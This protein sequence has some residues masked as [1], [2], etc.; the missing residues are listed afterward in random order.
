VGNLKSLSQKSKVRL[1]QL[2][3]ATG[4]PFDLTSGPN[5]KTYAELS[6][7]QG[8]EFIKTYAYGVGP[9]KKMIIFDDTLKAT[10]FIPDAHRVGLKVHPWTFR[11]ESPF[12]KTYPKLDPKSEIKLFL[13]LGVDGFFT[14]FT[15]TGVKARA[16]FLESQSLTRPK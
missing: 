14:D 4:S 6:S 2:L 12:L 10:S 9:N 7:P 8:L 3:D 16:E 13:A 1:I 11:N 15:D 5:P